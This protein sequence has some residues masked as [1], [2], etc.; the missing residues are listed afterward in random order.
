MRYEPVADCARRQP[1]HDVVWLARQPSRLMH[2]QV[3]MSITVLCPC[4]KF[5]HGDVLHEGLTFACHCGLRMQPRASQ[6]F[7]WMQP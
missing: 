4:C 7:T 3:S 1:L 2:G 5:R 6:I